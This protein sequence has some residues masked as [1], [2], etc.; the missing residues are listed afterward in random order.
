MWAGVQR[1]AVE[2]PLVAICAA[3]ASDSQNLLK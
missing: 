1:L 2:A 3:G